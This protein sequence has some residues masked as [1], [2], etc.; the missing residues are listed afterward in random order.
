MFPLDAYTPYNPLDDENLAQNVADALEREPVHRLPPSPFQGPGL[1][2]IYYV[3][4]YEL[5]KPLSDLCRREATPESHDIGP[6]A[7]PMYVGKAAASGSRKGTRKTTNRELYNRIRE[8]ANS[9]RNAA[10][11]LDISDFRVRYLRVKDIWIPL[12]EHGII[13]RYKPIWNRVVDGFGNHAQGSGRDE[14]S[15]SPWDMIHPG[16]SFAMRLTPNP[17]GLEKI[18][19]RVRDAVAAI[20][21]SHQVPEE[22][23]TVSEAEALED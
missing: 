15:R 19:Q 18:E 8:H 16:R 21:T 4:K 10:S 6:F 20:A 12:G 1:Y 3:G 17:D 9:I 11:T 14:Q 5:Y 22:L 23:L 13:N 2:A 7:V